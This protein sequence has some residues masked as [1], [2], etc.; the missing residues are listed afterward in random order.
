MNV[1]TLN[2]PVPV[3]AFGEYHILN[4]I[5]SFRRRPF[6]GSVCVGDFCLRIGIP[7]DKHHHQDLL[8]HLED[9]LFWW[10]FSFE[11]S[12]LQVSNEKK[13]LVQ[14]LPYVYIYIFIYI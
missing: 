13:A 6:L 5:W 11:K 1:G 3:G 2:I 7:W 14:Y 9:Y 8:Y 12:Q 4:F 10:T